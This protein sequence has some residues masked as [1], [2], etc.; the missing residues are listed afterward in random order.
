MEKISRCGFPD[1]QSQYLAIAA[2]ADLLGWCTARH[3]LHLNLMIG[4]KME[5][6]SISK[7]FW[8][9][10]SNFWLDSSQKYVDIKACEQIF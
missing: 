10:L 1:F 9:I 2:A 8:D 3:S 4:E 6:Q 5:Y 7:M